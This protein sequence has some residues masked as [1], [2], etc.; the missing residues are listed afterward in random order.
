MYTPEHFHVDDLATLHAIVRRHPF[1]LLV[2]PFEGE[3]HMTHL[4]FHLDATGGPHGTLEAHLAKANPH[5]AAL[6]A[7]APS[8]VVFRGPDAYISPRFYE[9]P[10]RN[11]PTWSYVAV[12]AHGRPVA[13]EDPAAILGSIGRLTG[14]M[15]AAQSTP[16]TIAQAGPHAERLAHL[17]LAF[18]IPIERLEG[19][20]KL[21]Q[22]RPPH[23]RARVMN[24]LRTSTDS[25]AQEMVELMAGLY[26]PD[27]ST[28]A[29]G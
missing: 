7:G 10:T 3:L 17:V 2:T 25:A 8:V 12:H 27:G 9:D 19:K 16:W 24:E 29:N 4:P 18:D 6:R 20:L 23:D 1:A 14:D 15:E 5:C 11:V 21:S 26:H 22:N 13:H 28:R